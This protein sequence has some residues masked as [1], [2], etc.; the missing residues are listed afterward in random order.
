MC[1]QVFRQLAGKTSLTGELAASSNFGQG[2]TNVAVGYSHSPGRLESKVAA[3]SS[4]I[5]SDNSSELV[6]GNIQ[7]ADHLQ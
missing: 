3:P 5:F 6:G 1:T 7:S 2:L 4:P